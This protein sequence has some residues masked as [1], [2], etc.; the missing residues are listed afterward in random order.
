MSRN[1][2]AIGLMFAAVVGIMAV[3]TASCF[4]GHEAPSHPGPGSRTA[5]K[6]ASGNIQSPITSQ[7]SGPRSGGTPKVPHQQ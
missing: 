7:S 1:K 6:P 2:S 5:G 4:A 3:S